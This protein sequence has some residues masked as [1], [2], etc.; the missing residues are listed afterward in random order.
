MTQDVGELEL[1]AQKSALRKE[2]IARRAALSPADLRLCSHALAEKALDELPWR[3]LPRVSVFWSLPGEIETLPL[4]GRLEQSGARPLLPRMHGRGRPLTFH[5]W[6]SGLSLTP[7]PMQ[8]MEPPPDSPVEI[9]DIVLA[10]LLAFDRRGGR[11]GYGAGFYDRTLAELAAKGDTVV[12]VGYALAMQEVPAVP[13]G[14]N[15]VALE[16]VLTENGLIR[17]AA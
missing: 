4:L 11:L 14:P 12:V 6:S 13:T 2:M 9:P 8:V 3:R 15:D 7:G 17:C 10:P 1:R 16:S 5:P